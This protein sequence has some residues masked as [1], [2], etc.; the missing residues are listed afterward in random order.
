[1]VGALRTVSPC[2]MCLPLADHESVSRLCRPWHAPSLPDLLEWEHLQGASRDA[3]AQSANALPFTLAR[4]L[5][6]IDGSGGKDGAPASWAVLVLSNDG[7]LQ[8]KPYT[9]F[10]A[11]LVLGPQ[12]S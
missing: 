4:W 2:N 8:L 9:A 3:L 1:M 11:G 7:H 5:I 10:C 6:S 12:Q